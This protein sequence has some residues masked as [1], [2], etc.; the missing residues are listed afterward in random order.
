MKKL[1]V[2]FLFAS[3]SQL[4][5]AQQNFPQEKLPTQSAYLELGGAGLIYSFNYDFRFDSQRIDGWGMRIG[6]GGY[7][8]SYDSFF[9]LPVMVNKLYGRGPHF[10]EMGLGVTLFSFDESS[11]SN[12]DY[13]VSGSFDSN[14]NYI[15]NSYSDRAPY[16]FI[17]PVENNTGVMGTMNI[18]YRRIP[19]NGGFTWKASLSPVFNQ[20]GFWPLFVGFGFGYAF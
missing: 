20:N 12:Y 19:V 13:C 8:T 4:S 2:V 11:Y 10:F 3:L 5:F 1:L 15:C 9:S 18:G 6:A 17:L 16:Q 14:G 7:G